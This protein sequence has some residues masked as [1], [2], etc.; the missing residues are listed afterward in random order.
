MLHEEKTFTAAVGDRVVHN[1]ALAGKW[2]GLQ[3][4]LD[5]AGRFIILNDGAVVKGSPALLHDLGLTVAV[6]GFITVPARTLSNGRLVPAFQVAQYLCGK[7]A[8]GKAI[9]SADTKPWVNIN[10]E[11]SKAACAAVGGA[12]IIESQWLSIA[13]DIC[14][15]DINWTGGKVG[16]GKVFQGLHRGTVSSAQPGTFESPHA[17]ERRWHQLSNGERIY[18]FA[19]N[20]FSWVFD[21]VQGD[22]KGL[23]GKIVENSLSLS[24]APYPSEKYGMGYR[25]DGACDWSG[26]ALLRGGCWDS[27]SHSGVFRLSYGWPGVDDDSVGFR[28]TLPIGL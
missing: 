5:P 23:T 18:D 8:D 9:I 20:A 15:Q 25:P 16:E 1:L 22:D 6:T 10:F 4:L 7:G 24:I 26:H 19:G 12:L 11:S 28:C 2:E 21:D 3:K 17:D 13:L 14:E 27:G